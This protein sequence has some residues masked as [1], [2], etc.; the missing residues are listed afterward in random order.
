MH[1]SADKG[2]VSLIFTIIFQ[3][4]GNSRKGSGGAVPFVSVNIFCLDSLMYRRCWLETTALIV[5]HLLNIGLYA[6]CMKELPSPTGARPTPWK[7]TPRL[8]NLGLGFF[9]FFLGMEEERIASCMWRSVIL[10]FYRWLVFLNCSRIDPAFFGFKGFLRARVCVR[11]CS[12][13]RLTLASANVTS[14]FWC[15]GNS[16]ITIGRSKMCSLGWQILAS[17]SICWRTRLFFFLA[18]F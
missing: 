8:W 5:Q 18:V 4:S 11:V 6:G 2:C 15:D 16:S 7:S 3:F 12:L 1:C 14:F 13:D 9:Y 17:P 10:L